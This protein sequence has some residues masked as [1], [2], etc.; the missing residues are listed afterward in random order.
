MYNLNTPFTVR[1]KYYNDW[2]ITKFEEKIIGNYQK[3]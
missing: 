2:N 3:S 1:K